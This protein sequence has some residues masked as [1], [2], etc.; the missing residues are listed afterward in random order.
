[1]ID[2][3]LNKKVI[4]CIADYAHSLDKVVL[5]A[6]IEPWCREGIMTDYDEDYIELDHNEII[7]IKYIARMKE[8]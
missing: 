7:A 6:N 8:K 1:M 3:F 2:K 4:V 5:G